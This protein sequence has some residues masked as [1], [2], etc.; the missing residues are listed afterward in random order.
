MP[1]ASGSI[2][3][4]A[5]HLFVTLDSCAAWALGEPGRELYRRSLRRNFPIDRLAAQDCEG[6]ARHLVGERHGDK[7]EG[8]LVDQLLRPHPQ[9]VGVRLAVKQHRMRT[10]D[11]QFAQIA[12]AHLRKA[13]ELRL[14]AR[15]VL[16]GRQAEKGRELA[17]AGE[18]RRILNG[19]SGLEAKSKLR[20]VLKEAIDYHSSRA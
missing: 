19:R 1:R 16:L 9:R 3:F 13:P 7:L 17:R 6:D 5:H 18:T 4:S 10:H 20:G 15:R 8:L 2:R 11:K 12:I 14:A